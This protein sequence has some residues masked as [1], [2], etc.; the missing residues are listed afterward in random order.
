MSEKYHTC[1][2]CKIEYCGQ[3]YSSVKLD[4]GVLHKANHNHFLQEDMILE[5][6][7]KQ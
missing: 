6:Q 4:L 5:F 2:V 7:K 3:D 1:D